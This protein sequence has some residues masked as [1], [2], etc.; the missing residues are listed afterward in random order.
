MKAKLLGELQ[1]VATQ[2]GLTDTAALTALTNITGYLADEEPSLAGFG[3]VIYEIG[4]KFG[5]WGTNI[6]YANTKASDLALKID[7][8]DGKKATITVYLSTIGEIP[9]VGPNGEYIWPYVPVTPPTPPP[10]QGGQGG[11]A[12]GFVG[13]V[14][15]GFDND[16][17]PM[18]VESGEGVLVIPASKMFG[19]TLAR[20]Q[21]LF[22]QSTAGLNRASGGS[23]GGSGGGGSVSNSWSYVIQAANPLQTSGDLARQVRLLEL[24]H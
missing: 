20:M 19:N 15:Q 10:G 13:V 9:D 5:V 4:R 22:S 18:N 1:N 2:W 14:P 7:E 24:M 23:P 12:N 16:G 6:D 17:Y 8:L 11:Q 3:A 21:Q